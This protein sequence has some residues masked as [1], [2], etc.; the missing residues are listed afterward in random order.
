MPDVR[1][2]KAAASFLFKL[3]ESFGTQGVAFVV[4]VLLARLLSPDD[5]GVLTMLT[6]FIAISQV[7][8]QSGLNTALIQKLEIDET[9]RSSVFWV[10]LG[11]AGVLYAILFLCAPA[12]GT[13]YRMPQLAPVLRVLA[14]VLFPGAMVS[15][16]NAVVARE[17]KFQRL[18]LASLT[19]TILSGCVGVG[20]AYAGC[21]YWALV[22]QQ[23]T[24]QTALAVL[25]LI[26]VRWR[27]HFCFSRTRVFKLISFGWKLLFS[28][29]LETGYNKLR[30]LVV[31]RRFTA[32]ALGYFSRR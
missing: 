9:D 26:L 20:M 30:E 14:L 11:V 19:A 27:P 7:F 6:V 31:G 12:I 28:S 21:G 16:Q 17:M 25:L 23:L 15:V 5:Y 3:M 18:M 29:L 32:E 4:S 1:G 10:S 2:Q 8:V 13:F 24:N 22:A